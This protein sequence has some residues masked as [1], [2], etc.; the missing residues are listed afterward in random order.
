MTLKLSQD[1]LASM[2]RKLKSLE[3]E[4]SKNRIYKNQIAADN[5][6]VWHD[7]NDFEQCEIE[8]RRLMKEISDIKEKIIK[9]EIITSKSS[10]N[11]VDFGNIVKLRITDEYDSEELTILFSDSDEKSE[12]DKMAK[13]KNP[14]GDGTASEQI[15]NFILGE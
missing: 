1:G 7:N 14:Y 2:E 5:G 9:A 3:E 10:S 13:A 15:V 12:Y 8:E 11:I 4:L 6:N